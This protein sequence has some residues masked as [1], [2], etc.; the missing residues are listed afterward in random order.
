VSGRLHGG[1]RRRS[2]ALLGAEADDATLDAAL[3]VNLVGRHLIEQ[4]GREV[5]LG[6][7]QAVLVSWAEPSRLTHLPPSEAL[8]LRFPRARLAPLLRGADERYMRLIP[9]GE[10]LDLLTRYVALAWDES[11]TASPALQ[12]LMASHI[13]DL[14]AVLIGATPEAAQVAQTGGLHAARLGAIRE[15][16]ERSLDRPGLSV[17]DVAE[18][19]G[20]TP[21]GVQRLFEADGTTF[22]AYVLSRRLA[23]ARS[24]LTDPRHAGEKIIAVAHACGFGDVSYFN[25]AFRRHFGEAPSD[26]RAQAR[27]GAGPAG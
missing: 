12:R 8:A 14:M 3:F 22:T 26:V 13:Y 2:R 25:R 15:D 1:C 10:A 11:T 5:A 16:I 9:G 6:D 7:G 4:H 17:V 20:C 24:L 18:R 23:R 21:R 19:H 27:A